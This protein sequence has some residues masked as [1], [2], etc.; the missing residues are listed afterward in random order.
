PRNPGSDFPLATGVLQL[1]VFF[2]MN[3]DTTRLNDPKLA[4]NRTDRG[5]RED[6]A[7][8]SVK[9]AQRSRPAQFQ[10][11]DACGPFGR[12]ARNLTEVAIQCDQRA[13]FR[14][15]SLKHDLVRCASKPLLATGRHVLPGLPQEVDA[16]SAD[17]LIDLDLHTADATG[18]G[19]IRSRD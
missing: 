13:G 14:Y 9:A 2:Q 18:S 19:I 16:A 10:K 3:P 17:V 15:A 8:A 12:E 6:I 11:D 1:S 7:Q 4:A 5:E